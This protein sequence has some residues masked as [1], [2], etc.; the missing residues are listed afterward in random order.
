MLED[1]LAALARATRL[2]GIMV[3]TVDP[4]AADL[5]T[6]YGARVV[7][8][9]ARDGHTGAVNGVAR[10]LARGGKGRS[11]DGAG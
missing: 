7:T 11:A 2:A 4:A 8:E 6:R 1:V 5:A 3:N 10:I 9:G